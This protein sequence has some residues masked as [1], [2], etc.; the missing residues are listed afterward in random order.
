MKH[1]RTSV[2]SSAGQVQFSCEIQK[3]L[4]EFEASIVSALEY[5]MVFQ[6]SCIHQPY[7]S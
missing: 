4:A 5:L 6:H 3:A 7:I 1:P 2:L